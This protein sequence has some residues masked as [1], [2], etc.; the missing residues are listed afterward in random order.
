M[1]KEPGHREIR[2]YRLGLGELKKL[3][4]GRVLL[5]A[6][7]DDQLT[8]WIEHVSTFQELELVVIPTGG[9]APDESRHKGSAVVGSYVWHVYDTAKV[10]F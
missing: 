6:A 10:P 2:K 4:G 5:V 7:Q 3:P 9:F 8:V 1:S